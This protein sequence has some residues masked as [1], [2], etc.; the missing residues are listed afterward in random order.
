[1]RLGQ[2][3]S[4]SG[5]MWTEQFSA[6]LMTEARCVAK[7]HIGESRIIGPFSPQPTRLKL[8]SGPLRL[9]AAARA[10][11]PISSNP[12]LLYVI[13][14]GAMVPNIETIG[15]LVP[16]GKDE[17]NLT[18]CLAR[19]TR[20]PKEQDSPCSAVN[21]DTSTNKCYALQTPVDPKEVIAKGEWTYAYRE[22]EQADPMPHVEEEKSAASQLGPQT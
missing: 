22:S 8:I 2:R 14:S 21:Y 3:D 18:T 13:T 16:L 17:R 20:R 7:S 12:V 11:L 1:M 6:K 9:T 5:P 10:M 15:H 19:C 4:N